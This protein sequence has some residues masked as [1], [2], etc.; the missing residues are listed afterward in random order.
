MTAAAGEGVRMQHQ[1][2]VL[3]DF[4][5]GRGGRHSAMVNLK[6]SPLAWLHFRKG[7][8][9]K[10]LIDAAQFE[11]GERLRGDYSFAAI[12]PGLASMRWG[13]PKTDSGSKGLRDLSDETLDA[14]ARVE[15]ALATVGPELSGVLVDVCCFLKGLETVESERRWPARSAKLVLTLA[16]DRLARHY[17]LKK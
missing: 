1:V 8:A 12:R 4:S 11:A 2:R 5:D 3:R 7:K 9:G 16:L 17:G 10:P 15:R 6:E 14:R 13:E